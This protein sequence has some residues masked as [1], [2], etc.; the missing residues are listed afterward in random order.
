MDLLTI[1]LVVVLCVG[2]G[3]FYP[4]IPA[5]WSWVIAAVAC[6]LCLLALASRLGVP[7]HL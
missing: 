1:I 2:V 5:P 6:I 3:Y 4:K 7:L